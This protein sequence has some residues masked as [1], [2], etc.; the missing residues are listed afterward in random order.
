MDSLVLNVERKISNHEPLRRWEIIVWIDHKLQQA[1][2]QAAVSSFEEIIRKLPLALMLVFNKDHFRSVIFKITETSLER[3][4]DGIAGM[5]SDGR[6]FQRDKIIGPLRELIEDRKD[7]LYIE[8]VPRDPR[9]GYIA[10]L[11]RDPDVN[12]IYFVKVETPSGVWVVAVDSISPQKIDPEK[13]DFLVVLCNKI[14]KIEQERSEALARIGK[15]IITTQRGTIDYLLNLLA[16]LFRNKVTTVGG[17]CRRIDKIAENGNNGN[18]GVNGDCKKC[19]EKTKNVIKEAKEI[20]RILLEFDI[21]LADIKKATVINLESIPLT[22]LVSDIQREDPLS[23]FLI[24]LEDPHSEFFLLTDKRKT[25][26]ALCRMVKKLTQVNKK[27]VK[28]SAREYNGEKIRISL[29]QDGIDTE[30]L[31]RLV[32]VRENG[33]AKDHSLSDFTVIISSILL[34]ELGITIEVNHAT[35]DFVFRGRRMDCLI[36][37]SN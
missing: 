26:K 3:I 8:D 29:T 21:A 30:S 5:H 4:A 2:A 20:E 16:H 35:V 13:K 28:V 9:N 19:S 14:K 34:P 22:I 32:N 23:D 6:F 24:E 12:D 17:L 25:V 33:E 36:A 37:A 31:A 7:N 18:G 27:P 15:E 1:Q 11:V 10:G